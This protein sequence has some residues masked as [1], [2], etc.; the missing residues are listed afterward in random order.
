MPRYPD[1][2]EVRAPRMNATV[3]KNA[4]AMDEGQLT[5]SSKSHGTLSKLKPPTEARKTKMI[6]EKIPMKIHK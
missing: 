1:K 3:L 6:T 4:L 5:V 2:V